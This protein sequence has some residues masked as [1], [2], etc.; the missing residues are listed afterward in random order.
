RIWFFDSTDTVHADTR[1]LGGRLIVRAPD[2]QFIHVLG[3]R[4]VA[5]AE[6]AELN[7]ALAEYFAGVTE[8]VLTLRVAPATPAAR[9][10]LEPGDVVGPLAGRPVHSAREL[11]AALLTAAGP[12]P[13][14]APLDA[15]RRCER[16]AL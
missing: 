8:G 14:Q 7:P 2:V 3:E 4:G 16:R 13:P 9:A 11:R 12:Q 5:G 15:V 6:F 10:Q 1:R